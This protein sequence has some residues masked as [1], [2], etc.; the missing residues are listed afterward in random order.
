MRN[1]SCHAVNTAPSVSL[2]IALRLQNQYVIPRDFKSAG[3][4]LYKHEDE[5]AWATLEWPELG[6]IFQVSLS[7]PVIALSI[8]CCNDLVD[9]FSFPTMAITPCSKLIEGY[10]LVP[11][12][13]LPKFA[14]SR[15]FTVRISLLKCSLRT[16]SHWYVF[17]WWVWMTNMENSQQFWLLSRVAHVGLQSVFTGLFLKREKTLSIHIYYSLCWLWLHL[18]Q[19]QINEKMFLFFLKRNILL[20]FS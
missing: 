5:P 16:E 13:N 11:K 18:S 3:G 9:S 14:V 7:K 8:R 17:I 2:N 19:W 1:R 20:W 6:W 10:C 12:E 4:S 15:G